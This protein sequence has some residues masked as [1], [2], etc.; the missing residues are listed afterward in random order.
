MVERTFTLNNASGL[1]A[2]P[3]SLFVQTVQKYPG[4]E[5]QVRKGDKEV[6]A[7]SL[8][9]ILSLGVSK[10]DTLTVR[11]DGPQESEALDALT[12]LIEGGFGE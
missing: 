6:N 12:T 5:V 9:S 10:G 7:R 2:R 3:A 11:C 8:L 1:H 4:T